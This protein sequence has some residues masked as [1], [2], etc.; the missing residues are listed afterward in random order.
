MISRPT[1]RM[2]ATTHFQPA[3]LILRAYILPMSPI[4]MIPTTASPMMAVSVL[5]DQ[6]EAKREDKLSLH[7]LLSWLSSHKTR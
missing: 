7:K 4:P 5:D 6:H 1:G 2:D 3:S